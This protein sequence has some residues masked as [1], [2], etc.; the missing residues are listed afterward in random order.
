[1][2]IET[3]PFTAIFAKLWEMVERHPRLP[4]M[5]KPGNR[6]KLNKP[7]DRNPTKEHV[8]EAD[9]PELLLTTDGGTVR[10]HNTSSST[11]VVRRYSWI[12]STGDQRVNY[13]LYPVEW[14]LVEAL[15]DWQTQISPLTFKEKTFAKRLDVLDVNEGW[16]RPENR[17]I[18]GWS[19]LWKCEIEMH[20]KTQDLIDALTP[21]TP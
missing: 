20:F 21:P 11:K 7:N 12:V 3:D 5:V 1:M 16:T 19:A 6:I 17:N 9:L 13:K 10:L 18:K 4:E 8:Q 14:L 2:E 15:A